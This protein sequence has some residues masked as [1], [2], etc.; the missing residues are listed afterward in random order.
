MAGKKWMII[1]DDLESLRSRYRLVQLLENHPIG[2]VVLRVEKMQ[3]QPLFPVITVIEDALAASLWGESERRLCGEASGSSA[4]A[5]LSTG[6]S[7]VLVPRPNHKMRAVEHPKKK[8]HLGRSRRLWMRSVCRGFSGACSFEANAI[9]YARGREGIELR[10][11]EEQGP[12][13]YHANPREAGGPVRYGV[14][15]ST[16]EEAS[17]YPT[18]GQLFHRPFNMKM[19]ALKIMGVLLPVQSRGIKECHAL[20]LTSPLDKRG[21]PKYY[22]HMLGGRVPLS[23]GCPRVQD[24]FGKSHIMNEE[25]HRRIIAVGKRLKETGVAQVSQ[26]V[27]RLDVSVPSEWEFLEEALAKARSMA[28]GRLEVE[29][30]QHW[31]EGMAKG[32]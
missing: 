9:V 26:E 2:V 21:E 4:N 6:G 5:C 14:L 15:G 18:A 10:V 23:V 25:E 30:A 20:G 17:L 32:E 24:L 27:L 31:V 29:L 8:K 16:L 22:Y 1:P 7:P 11:T 12:M 3:G 19:R 28:R 13:S